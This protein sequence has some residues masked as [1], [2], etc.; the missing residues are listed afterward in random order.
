M[1]AVLLTLPCRVCNEGCKLCSECCDGCSDACNF[2][3]KP[4]CT[5][6][7]SPFCLFVTVTMA[8]NVPSIVMATMVLIEY[9]SN[10]TDCRGVLWSAINLPLCIINVLASW[11]IALAVSEARR[12]PSDSNYYRNSTT[13]SRI[14][15]LLCYDNCIAL[16]ILIV[17]GFVAWQGVGSAWLAED[18][19]QT[20]PCPTVVTDKWAIALGCG[21]MFMAV[22]GTA[23]CLS[24]CCASFCLRRELK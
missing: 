2:I 20:N 1:A 3:F 7:R 10:G 18:S 19:T 16:Y 23:L 17:G 8:F 21:W 14:T 6:L 22:G 11:Y 4:L 12:N 9:A 24:A 5:L 15:Y 13:L